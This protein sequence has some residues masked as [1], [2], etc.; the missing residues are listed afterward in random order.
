VAEGVE[1]RDQA[2]LLAAMGC[3]EAQGYWFG[4]PLPADEFATQWL[5][6]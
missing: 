3:N 5:T 1:T 2:N 6:T 4:R